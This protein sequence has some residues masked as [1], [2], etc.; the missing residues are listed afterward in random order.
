MFTT[1][2]EDVHQ[3]RDAFVYADAQAAR[4]QKQF[5]DW[6]PEQVMNEA[7]KRAREAILEPRRRL[8]ELEQ[9]QDPQP[10]QPD[11]DRQNAKQNLQPLPRQRT[12]VQPT[13]EVEERP[14]TP[15]EALEEI[16]A[17]RNQP[18]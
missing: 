16:R 11:A 17:G 4:I 1:T 2:Y 8:Q 7:G 6:T 9:P 18:V 3:D 15:A 14:Q 5:P 10:Q 12:D 13:E